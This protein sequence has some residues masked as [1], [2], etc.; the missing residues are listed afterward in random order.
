MKLPP[1]TIPRPAIA[2]L[3]L[4]LGLVACGPGGTNAVRPND[5]AIVRA[6]IEAAP[7]HGF[8]PT[9]FSSADATLRDQLIAYANAQHGADR[10]PGSVEQAWGMRA[11]T[12]DARAEFAQAAS[13]G[14][15]REWIATL[16]PPSPQYAALRAAFAHYQRIVADGGWLQIP[17]G[18]TLRTGVSGANVALL[19][20][21]LAVE[22]QIAP[23]PSPDR[24]DA[25][26]AQALRMAQLRYGIQ[27]TGA[28]DDA[29]RS[30]LNVT[31]EV[32]LMQIKANL[33]R[34]RWAPRHPAGTR[35]DVNVPAGVASYYVD[36]ARRL[37]MRIAVG[38]PGDETPMLTAT[39]R[40]I[41]IN[42]PWNVPESIAERELLPR[43]QREP[44]YLARSG[45]V[46][47]SDNGQTRLQQTPGPRSALGVVKFNFDN[48]Y[49]VYLHDTPSRAAF[50]QAR[51][52]VSHGC[53]RLERAVELASLV[54]AQQG[55]SSERLQQ[56]IA[57]GDT[58]EVSLEAPISVRLFYWTAWVSNGQVSFRDD[59]YHWDESTAR[60]ADGVAQRPP[61]IA[62]T[63]PQLPPA[64]DQA[65]PSDDEYIPAQ[66]FGDYAT[67][68]EEDEPDPD[69]VIEPPPE[70]KPKPDL[71]LQPLPST[72][73]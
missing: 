55:W 2:L 56:A 26:L 63:T 54:L 34:W 6:A 70:T 45:F 8:G 12:F 10:D 18:P 61:Q 32:R 58:Q 28:L 42:P 43:E 69:P 31:A 46:Q 68:N 73:N 20:Q 47:I 9:L 4:T 39:I 62:A 3:C 72:Q 14:H 51:R 35:I 48:R 25:S 17:A 40:S 5:R 53:V 37:Q 59:I 50:A 33:Q 16:A 36:N 65:I 7:S 13:T 30:A 52:S 24:F 64:T 27:P 71:S 67:T 49:G 15:L 66:N 57:A 1:R 22:T 11:E 38:R 41:V 21:R 60:L 19:R 29:T 44:G 23:N